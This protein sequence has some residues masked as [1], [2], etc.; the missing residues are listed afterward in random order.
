MPRS[1][2]APGTADLTRIYLLARGRGGPYGAY[3]FIREWLAER[4]SGRARPYRPPTYKDMRRLF[5]VL[6]RLGLIEPAGTEPARRGPFR[7]HLYRVVPGKE[8]DIRWLSPVNALYGPEE[9]A[10][11]SRL[12][13]F[14]LQEDEIR[15]IV[16]FIRARG[17]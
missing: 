6:R 4:Y 8:R 11:A 3:T 14:T 5:Y 2:F 12:P 17:L 15:E 7:R 13:H 9:F 10:A 16:E 1:P